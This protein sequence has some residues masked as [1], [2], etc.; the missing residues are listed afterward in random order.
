[1]YTCA[2][3]AVAFVG[4][5]SFESLDQGKAGVFCCI[6]EREENSKGEDSTHATFLSCYVSN[7]HKYST[8]SFDRVALFSLSLSC[9]PHG[10]RQ[11]Y[12]EVSILQCCLRTGSILSYL[13]GCASLNPHHCCHARIL[14]P[15]MIFAVVQTRLT[16]SFAKA[17]PGQSQCVAQGNRSRHDAQGSSRRSSH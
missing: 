9:S 3:H 12:C 2:S 14:C 7:L 1:M 13:E 4:C 15:T 17:D 6:T 5:V 16:H 11:H 8:V 10:S